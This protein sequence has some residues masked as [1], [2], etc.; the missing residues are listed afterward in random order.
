MLKLVLHKDAHA[1]CK[2]TELVQH[3]A[4]SVFNYGIQIGWHAVANVVIT[5]PGRCGNNPRRG[6]FSVYNNGNK[7]PNQLDT[8]RGDLLALNW[9]K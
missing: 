2:D 8:I 1:R 5:S 3:P 9:A 6:G 7:F 4:M